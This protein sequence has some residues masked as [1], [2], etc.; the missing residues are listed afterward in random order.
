M[1]VE[2]IKARNKRRAGLMLGAALSL[3]LAFG[4]ATAIY[5]IVDTL[6][7]K[8]LPNP[9]P[10]QLV[11]V[12]REQGPERI[13]PPV[14]GP[15]YFDLVREQRVFSDL[16]ASTVES[17]IVLP[18]GS[19]GEADRQLLARVS[20]N[21]FRTLGIEPLLGRLLGPSDDRTEASPVT[22]I[23]ESYWRS[24]FGASPAVVGQQ[25]RIN[26]ELRTIVGVWPAAFR[27]PARSQL[28]Q[29]LALA[30]DGGRRGNNS[31]N[32]VARLASGTSAEQAQAQMHQLAGRL[33]AQYPENHA[34]L[35]LR[36][37]S[38]VEAETAGARP[39]VGLLFTA[40]GLL[41]LVGCASL[42][43][44]VLAD[45]V[46]RRRE[47]ATR[48]AL[49]A[50]PWRLARQ[51]LGETA[52]LATAAIAIGTVRGVV[53]SARQNSLDR[54]AE[55]EVYL[56]YLA[57][58][59]FTPDTNLVVRTTQAQNNLVPAVRAIIDAAA[60]GVPVY[61]AVTLEAAI[62]RTNA[63]RSFLLTVVAFF[64]LSA[65]AIAAISLYAVLSHAVAERTNEIGI[66]L[67]LGSSRG[68]ILQSVAIEGGILVALGSALGIAAAVSGS[69][70]LSAYLYGVS[71]HNPLDYLGAFYA[72]ILAASISVLAPASK[73]AQTDPG[74]L[75]RSE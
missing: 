46:S 27:L 24:R 29:P 67:A 43:N 64:A 22:V 3:G 74:V 4:A 60:A 53:E 45:V 11:Q 44:L 51:L 28:A 35:D 26:G 57:S 40:I 38:L 39:V 75:L 56:S 34:E 13:G 69:N 16:A 63:E 41:T 17:G 73:A 32:L 61:G 58:P 14:S 68:R 23:A 1:A 20:G 36:V 12:L 52:L 62:E 48:S 21:Y 37:R 6:F 59:L 18:P 25:L 33:A 42:A 54:P 31:L 30:G 71:S 9:H 70:L 47:L 66:R 7:L 15:A 72:L 55:P 8:P 5:S 19:G 10:E 50:A 49:G 2:L 65:L